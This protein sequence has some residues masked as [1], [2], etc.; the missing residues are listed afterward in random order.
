[1]GIR[2]DLAVERLEL[3][4]KKSPAWSNPFRR[5][6]SWHSDGNRSGGGYKCC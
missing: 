3:A 6:H 5:N 1:M 4:E 2:T